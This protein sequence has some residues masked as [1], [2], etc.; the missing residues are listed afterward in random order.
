MTVKHTEV[1]SGRRELG[2]ELRRLRMQRKYSGHDVAVSL[3]WSPSRVSRL[4]NGLTGVG[5]GHLATLLAHYQVSEE[6]FVRLFELNRVTLDHSRI[7]PHRELLADQTG[8][9]SVHEASALRVTE[10]EPL[11]IP[12]LLQ[13]PEYAQ[14]LLDT[15]GL[16]VGEVI[17][18]RH[19]A[20]QQRQAILDRA[21]PT[22]RFYLAEHVLRAPIGDNHIMGRQLRRLITV[23][24][25]YDC[26]IRVLPASL[27]LSGA[28]GGAFQF[29]E[30]ADSRDVVCTHNQTSLVFQESPADV[31]TYHDILDRLHRLALDKE[32]SIQVINDL[33]ITYTGIIEPLSHSSSNGS[34]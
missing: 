5:G 12:T 29:L 17:D 11:A 15:A 24:V 32:Q 28:F 33:A 20:L 4:E 2:E 27:G 3:G 21:H 14:A 26:T 19:A 22:L 25:R 1:T 6:V 8:V 16:V 23:A 9:V 31:A 10:Y 18:R 30:Y 7:R 34:H 13:T